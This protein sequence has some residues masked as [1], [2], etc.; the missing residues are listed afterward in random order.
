MSKEIK[1]LKQK[2]KELQK[3]NR[4]LRKVAKES[5]PILSRLWQGEPIAD[6]FREILGI[7]NKSVG[8]V[9]ND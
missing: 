8:K 3:E 9:K 2:N 4:R 7:K 1:N 6:K 5:L